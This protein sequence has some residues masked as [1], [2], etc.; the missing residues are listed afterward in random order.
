MA[1]HKYV[2]VSTTNIFD[3][4]PIS[5]SYFSLSCTNNGE[6]K[7]KAQPCGIMHRRNFYYFFK[8]NGSLELAYKIILCAI[9]QAS[10]YVSFNFG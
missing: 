2:S 3:I 1:P 10:K 4:E 5:V 7:L 8:E 9:R 6:N